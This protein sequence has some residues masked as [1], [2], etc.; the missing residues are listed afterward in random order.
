M[1]SDS[2]FALTKPPVLDQDQVGDVRGAALECTLRLDPGWRTAQN[3]RSR[4]AAT[5]VSSPLSALVA[6]TSRVDAAPRTASAAA[7]E[8]ALRSVVSAGTVAISCTTV[9]RSMFPL[10]GS[11]ALSSTV[12]GAGAASAG[13]SAASAGALRGSHE[14][15]A[16]ARDSRRCDPRLEAFRRKL[17]LHGETM[18]RGRGRNKLLSSRALRP[19]DHMC[20][21]ML[22]P[23]SLHLISVAPS[24]R[25]AKS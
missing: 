24:I 14:F 18:Q 13:D 16:Q 4:A 19:C 10:R 2:G 17:R 5:P 9:P 8:S 7:T 23:N 21:M 20:A 25:R 1:S 22:S 15:I 11:P 12:I 6:R 3:R